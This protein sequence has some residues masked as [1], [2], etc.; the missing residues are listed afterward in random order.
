MGFWI[1]AISAATSLAGLLTKKKKTPSMASIDISG[2]L[3]KLDKLYESKRGLLTTD[4]QN[5]LAG[6]NKNTANSLAGRGIYR[7]PVSQASY[8]QNAATA[9]G[10]LSQG[11][12]NLYGKQASERTSSL[13]NLLG[14][15]NKV[16]EANY[17]AAL[18]KYQNRYNTRTGLMST[19][20]GMLWDQYGRKKAN[21]N[22]NWNSN[23]GS[24]LSDLSSYNDYGLDNIGDAFDSSG[25]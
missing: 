20:F 19:G 17:N 5:Q 18:R 3:D 25:F 21:N 4:I 15:Q 23:S 24:S 7:S 16:N 8:N 2:E 6:L 11:L 12:S 10:A 9:Q 14:Y 13:N 1:P 22:Y